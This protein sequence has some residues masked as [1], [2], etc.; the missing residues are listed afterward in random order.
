MTIEEVRSI[1]KQ[2]GMNPPRVDALVSELHPDENGKLSIEESAK[3]MASIN[4]F[5]ESMSFIRF[6]L[7]STKAIRER[8]EN[9]KKKMED[10]NK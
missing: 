5:V 8:R 10:D 3:A 6:A 1:A 7:D 9:A 4:I 2:K